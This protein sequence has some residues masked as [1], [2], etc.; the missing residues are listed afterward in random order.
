MLTADPGAKRAWGWLLQFM[1][2]EVL[3]SMLQAERERV[4]RAVQELR[5]YHAPRA[6]LRLSLA[7]SGKRSSTAARTSYASSTEGDSQTDLR[8]RAELAKEREVRFGL[9]KKLAKLQSDRK[10]GASSSGS[11]DAGTDAA[12]AKSQACTLL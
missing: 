3:S 11:G 12:P 10:R 5:A 1:R 8:L 7:F 2:D 9:E 4:E 6:T